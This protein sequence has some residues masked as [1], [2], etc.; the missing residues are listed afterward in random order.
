MFQEHQIDDTAE[1]CRK[2]AVGRLVG[3]Q[4]R[5]EGHFDE[6]LRAGA[7]SLPN[8]RLHDPAYRLHRSFRETR[9]ESF[10]A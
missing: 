1:Y 6:A 5:F 8:G 9:C 2:M 10:V 4:Q 3:S 7:S